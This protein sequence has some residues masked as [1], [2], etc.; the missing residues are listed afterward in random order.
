MDNLDNTH[1]QKVVKHYYQEI[2]RYDWVTEPKYPEKLHHI[3]RRRAVISVINKLIKN[4]HLTILDIGCGTG[5]ITSRLNFDHVNALDMNK[6]ALQ[7]AIIHTSDRVNFIQGDAENLPVA[8]NMFDL[9][10]STEMLEHLV[11]PESA[12]D[13]IYRI[14]KPGGLFI[15]TVPA[16][17]II[18]KYRK[19]L[20]T[21]CPVSEPFHNNYTIKEF[22][23]L[24]KNFRE[25]K[26]R[27]CLFKLLIIFIVQKP[28]L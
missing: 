18:F 3:L 21:T 19:F 23:P 4:K 28:L 26:V 12:L 20:T 24:L 2:E 9:V 22:T 15:G 14:M 6:W 16:K 8:S 5:F 17:H 27:Y 7:R 25:A 13:E 1:L 11:Q 10:V